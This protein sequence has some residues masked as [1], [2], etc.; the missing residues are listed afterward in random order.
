MKV[1]LFAMTILGLSLI[2]YGMFSLL[3]NN[4][5]VRAQ[6]MQHLPPEYQVQLTNL[7]N[8]NIDLSRATSL[9]G[10]DPTATCTGPSQDPTNCKPGQN[11]LP[12]NQLPHQVTYPKDS[13]PPNP[14]GTEPKK[15]YDP[16]TAGLGDTMKELGNIKKNQQETKKA[17]DDLMNEK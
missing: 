12:P 14:A 16:A 1:P 10:F 13:L 9:G 15:E 4:P 6:V 5:E 11:G 17:L 7:L 2:A 3:R 8:T